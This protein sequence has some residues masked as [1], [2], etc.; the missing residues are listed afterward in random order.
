MQENLIAF[1]VGV[2]I[3][4][5]IIKLITIP[6]RLFW[7]FIVNSIVGAIMLWVVSLFGVAVKINIIS[8]LI[9]GVLGVP[10]VL[11]IVLY[12]YM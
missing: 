5:I 11:I 8:S 3:L 4:G 2:V 12:S 1:A 9:A 7:K 10:G 6:F